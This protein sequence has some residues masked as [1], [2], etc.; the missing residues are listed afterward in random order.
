M[1]KASGTIRVAG[2]TFCTLPI[3]AGS[4][5]LYSFEGGNLQFQKQEYGENSTTNREDS[6]KSQGLAKGCLVN[7]AVIFSL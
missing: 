1:L 6:I 7:S 4:Y 5:E 2:L 3:Q